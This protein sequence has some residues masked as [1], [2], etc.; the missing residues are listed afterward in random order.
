[1]SLV[2]F[3]Q[4]QCPA[5]MLDRVT[6]SLGMASVSQ[7]SD[8]LEY[9]AQGRGMLVYPVSG[10][11]LD[12]EAFKKFWIAAHKNTAVHGGPTTCR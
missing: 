11:D 7:P 8:P 4:G 9:A 2:A 3:T 12:G 6:E 5:N 10:R 1:M